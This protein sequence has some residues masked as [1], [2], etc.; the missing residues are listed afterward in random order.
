MIKIYQNWKRFTLCDEWNLRQ[1]VLERVWSNG[2]LS[3]SKCWQHWVSWLDERIQDQEWINVEDGRWQK[4]RA[5]KAISPHHLSALSSFNR[6]FSLVSFAFIHGH[7]IAALFKHSRMFSWKLLT[8]TGE[9][10]I[11]IYPEFYFSL[12]CEFWLA[13]GFIWCRIEQIECQKLWLINETVFH[14]LLSESTPEAFANAIMIESHLNNFKQLT[15][16]VIQWQA[17]IA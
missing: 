15:I 14:K 11:Q 7:I 4:G 6:A 5:D 3:L 12:Y 8:W 2:G 1:I 16:L 9:D 17:T 13:W 10:A